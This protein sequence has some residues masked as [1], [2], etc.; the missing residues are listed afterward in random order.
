MALIIY[1]TV[2]ESLLAVLGQHHAKSPILWNM[3]ANEVAPVAESIQI[4]I[5]P[6]HELVSNQYPSLFFSIMAVG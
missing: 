5:G 1:Q 2:G 6:F 4:N 3:L